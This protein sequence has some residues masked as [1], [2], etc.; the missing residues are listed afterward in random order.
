MVKIENKDSAETSEDNYCLG[1]VS[2]NA[3]CTDF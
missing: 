1:D 3:K 2:L